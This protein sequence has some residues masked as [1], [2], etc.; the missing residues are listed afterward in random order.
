[1]RLQDVQIVLVRPKRTGNVAAACRAMKNMG[2]SR[3]LLVEPP[4]DL[5]TSEDRALA[6]GAFDVLD[7]A[8]RAPTLADAVAETTVVLATSGKHEGAAQTARDAAEGLRARAEGEGA[9]FVFGPEA[10]GLTRAELDRCHGLVHI[11]TSAEHASLNLAQAVMVVAY[12]VFLALGGPGGPAPAHAED[13]P[14]PAGELEAVLADLRAALL[15]IGFLN[16]QNPDAIL[17]ELR[18]LLARSRPTAREATLLRG[19]ARQIRWSGRP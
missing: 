7:G 14:V 11:P 19:L 9:A 6:Y 18:R 4:E 3:L 12:E 10:S 13:A 8:R 15:D 2:L 1:M 17:A 5:A 16:P